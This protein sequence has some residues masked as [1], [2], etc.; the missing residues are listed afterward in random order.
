MPKMRLTKYDDMVKAVASDRADQ[1]LTI[2]VLPFNMKNARALGT[3]VPNAV[4]ARA[5]EVIE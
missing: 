4:L 3:T 5:D 1:P 2:S